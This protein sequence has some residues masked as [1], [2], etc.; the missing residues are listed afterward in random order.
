MCPGRAGFRRPFNPDCFTLMKA[1]LI[2]IIT[3]AVA[4]PATWFV[5]KRFGAESHAAG[6]SPRGRKVLYYQSAMHPWVKSDKPGRCTICGMV[7]T[8]VYEGEPG[9]GGDL[10]MLSQTRFRS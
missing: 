5:A 4:V 9:F 3:L 8:P 7:L 6:T 1:A 10:P 2:V